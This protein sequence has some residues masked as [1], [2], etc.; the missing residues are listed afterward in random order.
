MALFNSPLG[1][2]EAYTYTTQNALGQKVVNS[3]GVFQTRF[4]ANTGKVETVYPTYY[5]AK[6]GGVGYLTF[7]N[8]SGVNSVLSGTSGSGVTVTPTTTATAQ[9]SAAQSAYEAAIKALN[10]G[11]ES[12]KSAR[13]LSAAH[14]KSADADLDTARGAAANITNAVDN[15][16]ATAQS[17]GG[18][19]DI[20]RNMGLDTAGIA[21]AILNKDTTAGGLAAEYLT[22][23]GQA[24]DAALKITPDRYVSQAAADVQSSFDNA[25]GQAERSLSR[26]G[27]SASSGAYGALQKQLAT[28][29]A[30]ALAAAKTKARQTGLSD[31]LS[32]LTSRASMMK[33]ALTTGAALQQQGASNIE[34]AAGIVQKQ[35]DLFATAG[36]LSQSQASTFANIGNV[37]VSLGNLEATNEK[38]VQDAIGNVASMQAQMAKYYGDLEIAQLPTTKTDTSYSYDSNGNATRTTTTSKTTH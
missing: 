14:I 28:S 29:L 30:T 13:D 7:N 22:A 3:G 23:L 38:L 20:L 17:L 31:Q 4:N 16:N 25:K 18:Y 12:A 5:A 8:S 9:K 26:Q 24:G 36:S 21:A 32:A 37:E 6:N 19:S 11:V 35:A 1:Q 33:D 27:V 34:S 15:V 2:H 10:G